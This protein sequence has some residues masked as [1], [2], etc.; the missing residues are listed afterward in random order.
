MRPCITWY[1]LLGALPDASSEDIQQA[2]DAKA[3][4]LRP[5]LLSD[6]PSTVVTAAAREQ[7][8]ID[9]ARRVLGD[10]VR[11]SGTTKRPACGAAA[12][13]WASPGT[14]P[15]G[16]GCRTPISPPVTRGRQCCAA[17]GR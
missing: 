6:A 8:I 5:E 16:P 17:W 11:R 15:P 12:G 2:Y 14:T 4:L 13:A 9:A 10:P 1:D 3:G 7:G